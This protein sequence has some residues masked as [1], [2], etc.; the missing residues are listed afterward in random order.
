MVQLRR[1]EPMTVY[2]VL[3][4]D[5]RQIGEVLQPSGI[6][7]IGCGAGTILLT[8][9]YVRRSDC[10]CTTHSRERTSLKLSTAARGSGDK[11][12]SISLNPGTSWIAP[13]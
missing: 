13:G 3:D 5:G 6:P 4:R 12:Q 10:P 2:E 7:T 1:R 8:R 11:S 9:R